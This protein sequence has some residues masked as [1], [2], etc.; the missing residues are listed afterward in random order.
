MILTLVTA[1]HFQGTQI[2]LSAVGCHN[3]TGF[4]LNAMIV[5]LAIFFNLEF[6]FDF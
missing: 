1:Q 3:E 6:D 2:V 5:P 4:L